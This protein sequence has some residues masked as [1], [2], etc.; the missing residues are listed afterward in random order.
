M[1]LYRQKL[2]V[3]VAEILDVRH[4][5]RGELA[6]G[7][8]RVLRTTEPASQVNFVNRKGLCEIFFGGAL[9][10]PFGIAPLIAINV[11]DD[12]RRFGR[13]FG[14]ETVRVGFLLLISLET[15]SYVVFVMRAFSGAGNEDLPDAAGAEP[16][17]MAADV[18]FVK[19]ACNADHLRVG[20]PDAE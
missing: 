6:I 5:S 19:V 2:N 9:L 12:R 7:Q 4:Q 17:G 15:R 14:C 18:P 13:D 10:L 11:E 1:L 20:R 8:Q 16:H 3:R